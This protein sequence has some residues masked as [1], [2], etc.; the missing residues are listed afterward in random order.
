MPIWETLVAAQQ[1]SHERVMAVWDEIHPDVVATD[2]VTGYPAVELAGCPWARIVSCNPLEMRDPALPPPL[3]GLPVADRG[4][5]QAFRDEYHRV[6][7]G[8]LREHN[9]FRASVGVTPCPPDEFNTESPWLNLYEFPEAADYARSRPLAATWHRMDSSVRTGEAP[10]AVAEHVPGTGKIVYLSLGSL[11]CMD[12]GL[13]QRLIDALGKT[14]APRHRLDGPAQGPDA[15]W[16]ADVRR[17]VPAAALD[18]A[19]VRPPDH[20]RRQQHGV[21][22]LPL[23]PAR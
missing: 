10:F 1:Y 14:A 18:P 7:E 6:H 9:D 11:G 5:W 16:S 17:R 20:P 21:R 8:L 23:R 22:G 13:M 12:V 2:N 15:A 19:A 3:S 4:E